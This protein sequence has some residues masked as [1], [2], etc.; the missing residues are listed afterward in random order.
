MGDIRKLSEKERKV[1]DYLK[2]EG[3]SIALA[4]LK[5]M[6]GENAV[7]VIGKLKQLEL[8]K[9]TINYRATK[10]YRKQ[11]ELKIKEEVESNG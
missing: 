9:I 8:I 2:V 1:Y 7:G 10:K 3:K 4:S 5:E 6:F 11:V